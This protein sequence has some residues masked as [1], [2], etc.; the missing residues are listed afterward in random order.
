VFYLHSHGILRPCFVSKIHATS[1]AKNHAASLV[2]DASPDTYWSPSTSAD[3]TGA[4]LVI[5]L[6]F[7]QDVAAVAF[8]SGA[9]DKRREFSSL[10][11]IRSGLLKFSTGDE[12][13]FELE[14]DPAVQQVSVDV[15]DVRWV[16][17]TVLSVY[18]GSSER[19]LTVGAVAPLKKTPIFR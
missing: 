2:F 7:M 19:Y 8:S 6:P 9:S 16:S 10:N 4:T 18:S 5:E 15:K 17:V 13:P 14:D 12:V 3:G 1:E 11:R